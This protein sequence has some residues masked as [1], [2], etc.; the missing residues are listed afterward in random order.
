MSQLASFTS[1]VSLLGY[2][3]EMYRFGSQYWL[4]GLS[5]FITQ[6]FSAHVYLPFFHRLK[7]TS[8]YE[9]IEIQFIGIALSV[10]HGI[11]FLVFRIKI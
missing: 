10:I 2:A 9:V 8:A 5:Y 3:H 1:A 4:Y 6:P 7:L 11:S